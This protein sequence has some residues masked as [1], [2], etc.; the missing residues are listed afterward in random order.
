MVHFLV[1]LVLF[2]MCLYKCFAE[3]LHYT[4][5]GREIPGTEPG[6]YLIFVWVLRF[7][8]NHFIVGNSYILVITSLNKEPPI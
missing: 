7:S 8:G 6:P 1:R 5:E 4:S 2:E 3:F